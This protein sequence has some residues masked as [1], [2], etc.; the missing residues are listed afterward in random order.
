MCPE[1]VAWES[2]LIDDKRLIKIIDKL[3]QSDYGKYLK[4]LLNN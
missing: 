3:S 4:N 1:E 2:G